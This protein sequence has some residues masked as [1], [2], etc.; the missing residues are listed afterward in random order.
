ML[1]AALTGGIATGKSYVRGRLAAL[2][3]PT[4]DADLLARDAVARGTPGFRAVADRF[5]PGVVRPDGTL[6]R[7]RLAAIVFTDDAARRDLEAIV[8][9]A[10]YAAIEAWLASLSAQ[11]PAPPVAVAD[12][13]LLFETGRAG[14][15]DAV[16]VAAC[17]PA[18]QVARIMARDGLTE[19]EA[20]RRLAAQWPIEEK[21]RRAD[22]V[23]ETGGSFDETDRQVRDVHAELLRR[24]ARGRADGRDHPAAGP[25]L[26][27]RG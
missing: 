25:D 15:F 5:G 10:V 22:F 19:T 27:R 13:P 20:R 24:A 8:H 16:I 11:V 17:A 14:A 23:I 21:V 26:T 9:P 7:A 12:V 6:D 2:G 18:L 3:V 4:L 1:K